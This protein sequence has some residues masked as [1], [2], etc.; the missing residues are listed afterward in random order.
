MLGTHTGVFG[1]FRPH[2]YIEWT[3][4]GTWTLLDGT[5]IDD[6]DVAFRFRV[7]GDG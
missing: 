3:Y 4:T 5:R 7:R 1:V 2:R 6:A